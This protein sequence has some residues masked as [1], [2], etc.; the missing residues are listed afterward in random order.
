MEPIW[1]AAGWAPG[2]P[3]TRDEVRLRR[4][5]MREL[6]LPNEV[7]SCL[8]DSWECLGH[9]KDLCNVVVGRAKACPDATDVAWIRRVLPDEQD[10]NQSR[11][12]TD[13]VWRIVQSAKF[14]DAPAEAR[15]LIRR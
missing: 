15:R 14:Q 6:G 2:V 10:S 11:W 4:R 3:V 9:Q 5:A 13:P 7:R 8:D 12:P 1:A